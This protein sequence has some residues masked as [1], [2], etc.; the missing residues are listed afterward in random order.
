[1]VAVVL[2]RLGGQFLVFACVVDLVVPVCF[3]VV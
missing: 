3:W 2:L 1:M